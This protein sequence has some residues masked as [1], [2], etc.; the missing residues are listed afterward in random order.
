MRALEAEI[1]K[2]KEQAGRL[3]TQLMNEVDALEIEKMK[4]KYASEVLGNR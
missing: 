4:I 2:S 3:K 1:K